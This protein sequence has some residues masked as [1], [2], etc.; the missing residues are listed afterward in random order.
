MRL[1]GYARISTRDQHPDAQHDPLLAA[2]CNELQRPHGQR[3]RTQQPPVPTSL[4]VL[5]AACR[6]T[7]GDG[8]GVSRS[9]GV[10]AGPT[11]TL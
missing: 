5:A 1:P 8:A 4:A 2:G 10:K 3:K 9:C 6:G 7:A 11:E